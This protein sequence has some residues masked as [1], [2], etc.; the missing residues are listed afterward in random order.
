V[1]K[2]TGILHF[3]FQVS[4][5]CLACCNL[6]LDY[7]VLLTRWPEE[8]GISQASGSSSR[9]LRWSSMALKSRHRHKSNRIVVDGGSRMRLTWMIPSKNEEENGRRS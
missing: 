9:I 8:N 4:E 6:V 1:T 5:A 2:G 7:R 3:K